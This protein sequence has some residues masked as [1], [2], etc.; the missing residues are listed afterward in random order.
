[1]RYRAVERM[2]A[3]Q[4]IGSALDVGCGPGDFAQLFDPA[5]TRY[6]GIDI[7]REYDRGMQASLSIT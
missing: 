1:M 3:H 4:T 6:L 2:L 5:R 7:S